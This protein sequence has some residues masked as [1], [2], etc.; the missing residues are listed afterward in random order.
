MTTHPK[1]KTLLIYNPNA[2]KKRKAITLGAADEI[3]NV[4]KLLEQYELK[5]DLAPTKHEGHAFEL[6]QYAIKHNYKEVYVAGGDGT[7]GEVAN[8]LVGSNV[9]LG[10]IPFGSIMNVARMLE[11]PV[12]VEKAIMLLKLGHTKKIDVGCVTQ[13][14]GK[15]VTEPMYFLESAGIG[16]DAQFQKFFKKYENGDIGMIWNILKLLFLFYKSRI[17]LTID[18]KTNFVK[19][20]LVNISNGPLAGAALPVAPDAKL[21]DHYLTVALYKIEVWDL[22]WYFIKTLFKRP[23]LKKSEAEFISAKRVAVDSYKKLPIHLDAR[24]F[25]KTPVEFEVKPS[26]LTVICG[27]PHEKDSAL[28]PKK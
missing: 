15:K 6:A 16:L 12:D 2:G 1:N 25:H 11:I 5:V 10:I 9:A 24:E 26:A 19:A 13:L 21:T 8:G 27:Y 17:G 22:I 28:S 18:G 14:E 7:V 20:T 23:N 4:L 3:E